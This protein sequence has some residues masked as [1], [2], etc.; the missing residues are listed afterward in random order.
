M[1]IITFDQLETEIR[2][3]VAADPE[4]VYQQGEPK[5]G[6]PHGIKCYYSV[7]T[8]GAV[9]ACLFG[10]AFTN[11]GVPADELKELEGGP[12]TEYFVFNDLTARQ[13]DWM[14]NLQSAQD[15]GTPWGRAL[16]DTDSEHPLS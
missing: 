10:Q 14:T 15:R 1:T 13:G 16:A 4:H 2:R 5:N 9:E 11:L 7:D 3:I 8:P 12:A 6:R